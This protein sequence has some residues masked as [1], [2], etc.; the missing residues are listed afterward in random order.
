MHPG[1]EQVGAEGGAEGMQVD[2]SVFCFKL[3]PSFNEIPFDGGDARPPSENARKLTRERARRRCSSAPEEIR[4]SSTT[5]PRGFAYHED[6][7]GG[8][9]DHRG[10]RRPGTIQSAGNGHRTTY[11]LYENSTN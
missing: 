9:R 4:D 11:K 10:G 6:V 2:P 7:T 8:N 3:N 1:V 5:L